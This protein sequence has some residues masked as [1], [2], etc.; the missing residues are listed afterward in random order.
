M[1]GELSAKL[2]QVMSSYQQH[3]P[4]TP[5]R[6]DSY[7]EENST[8][9]SSAYE[10]LQMRHQRHRQYQQQQQQQQQQQARDKAQA[11]ARK[12]RQGESPTSVGSVEDDLLS[13]VERFG[14][15][16]LSSCGM[17]DCIGPSGGS[18]RAATASN[19]RSRR[20]SAGGGGV[21]PP[22]PRPASPTLSIGSK[23]SVSLNSN[24]SP[25]LFSG[26]SSPP[27]SPAG[28]RGSIGAY[29]RPPTGAAGSSSAGRRSSASPS[30][31][32]SVVHSKAFP[33]LRNTV[34]SAER[35]QNGTAEDVVSTFFHDR[36]GRS[37][38]RFHMERG[39]DAVR[40]GRWTRLPVAEYRLDRARSDV[41]TTAATA[42]SGFGGVGGGGG[43]HHRPTPSATTATTSSLLD[44]ASGRTRRPP[45]RLP[46]KTSVAGVGGGP[47]L[48]LLG[49]VPPFLLS[50][51]AME[52]H[53]TFRTPVRV[54]AAG[55][56]VTEVSIVQRLFHLCGKKSQKRSSSIVGSESG[57]DDTIY[58][59]ES[60]LR[61]LDVPYSDR[62][63]VVMR[64][65]INTEHWT[66]VAAEPT[67]DECL[68]CSIPLMSGMTNRHTA[69]ARE[70]PSG[71][72]STPLSSSMNKMMSTANVRLEFEI[73]FHRTCMYEDRIRRMLTKK[74]NKLMLSW[75][76]WAQ[77][78]WAEDRRAAMAASVLGGASSTRMCMGVP[79]ASLPVGACSRLAGGCVD[80]DN[81]SV[82]SGDGG[83]SS[84][85]ARGAPRPKKWQ[86]LSKRNDS[87]LLWSMTDIDEQ[88]D[89]DDI[90]IED[91][92][93]LAS[94]MSNV[95]MHRLEWRNRSLTGKEHVSS[96]ASTPDNYTAPPVGPDVTRGSSTKR[97]SN[98][99]DRS[100]YRG[101][102]IELC[103][104]DV[105]DEDYAPALPPRSP[106]PTGTSLPAGIANGLSPQGVE[107]VYVSDGT[108]DSPIVQRSRNTSGK[109][110]T[111]AAAAAAAAGEISLPDLHQRMASAV[112]TP[113][114]GKPRSKGGFQR[115]KHV[116]GRKKPKVL[117]G[118]ET[119]I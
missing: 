52:R 48:S 88:D 26:G 102:G 87:F 38:G 1:G 8:M 94:D 98:E 17:E 90:V 20:G 86:S 70:N 29:A 7:D 19:H 95:G 45:S 103:L 37:M 56:S 3:R 40:F 35:F 28:S 76:L 97:D 106:R 77:D 47:S 34:S 100:S 14:E 69:A 16:I 60:V 63:R 91:E 96:I 79:L 92:G 115:R 50:R 4:V 59:I 41:S 5:E 9:A 55:M 99:N 104:S 72:R 30:P 10:E 105:D 43:Q 66:T 24:Y 2:S 112:S 109:V 58:V 49:N 33:P 113:P 93:S 27:S 82:V 23:G 12:R 67:I 74:I 51:P 31:L 108:I 83:I 116:F 21:P 53:G 25:D 42:V 13:S 101:Q 64:Q 111:E 62:F 65:T 80:A 110:A 15:L 73:H 44:A 46:S 81:G 39:D 36:A 18:G 119:D 22:A 118:E 78:G 117:G 84:A 89:E 114:L 11:Q 54:P 107:V 61:L 85:N 68:A 71:G 6:Y 32:S 57:D 75:C